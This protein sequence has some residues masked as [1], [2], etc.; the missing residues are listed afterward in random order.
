MNV[1]VVVSLTEEQIEQLIA[2]EESKGLLCQ[3]LQEQLPNSA[4]IPVI[5]EHRA[6]CKYNPENA[7]DKIQITD[8][9]QAHQTNTQIEI[10]TSEEHTWV[11]FVDVPAKNLYIVWR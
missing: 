10:N 5:N 4:C 3:L 9:I 2:R 11:W 1:P 6:L 8:I 7:V